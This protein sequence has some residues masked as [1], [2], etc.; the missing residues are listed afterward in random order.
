MYIMYM[1]Q[2]WKRKIS[3]SGF[4]LVALLLFVGYQA[5]T[6]PK[7]RVRTPIYPHDGDLCTGEPIVVEYEYDGELLG[8]HEC[9]V[10]CNQETARYILYTN[11]IATQCEPLPGCNDWGE[12]N[13]IMCTPPESR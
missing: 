5:V 1:M 13:G 3:W 2:Q 11:G 8:P 6:M 12:D 9:V 7:G 10:Q 4:V